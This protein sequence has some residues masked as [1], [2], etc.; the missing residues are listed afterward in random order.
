MMGYAVETAD[1]ERGHELD[2]LAT[3]DLARYHPTDGVYEVI[4][5]ASRFVKP[6]G[7]RIELDS[8]EQRLAAMGWQAVATGDDHRLVIAVVDTDPTT[9]RTAVANITTLPVSRIEVVSCD[10]LPRTASGKI[11]YRAVLAM[12]PGHSERTTAAAKSVTALFAEVLCRRDIRPTDTFASLGGDS[13]S[14]VECSLELERLLGRAPADW[15]VR[16]VEE[17]EQVRPARRTPLLDTSVLL[18][19]LAICAIVASHMK[20]SRLQGGGHLLLAL[21]GYNFAKFQLSITGTRDRVVAGVR[22]AA[23]VALPA[24]TWIGINMLVAGGYSLGCALLINN[25]SGSDWR[26]EGRWNYWIIEVFIQLTVFCSLLLA[27]PALR[28]VERQFPFGFALALLLPLL[29]F[30]FELIVIGSNYNYLFRTHT[31]AWIFLVG[32]AIQRA[33]RTW[34]RVTISAVSVVLLLGFFDQP[35]REWFIVAGLMALTWIPAIPVP[36]VVHRLLGVLAAASLW[37]FLVHWQVWPPLERVVGRE[38]SFAL[39]LATGIVV[40]RLVRLG[41]RLLPAVRAGARTSGRDRAT[42]ERNVPVAA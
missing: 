28:R 22:S 39:T 5:R 42:W 30:R 1:L 35:Q 37:I 4:G 21:I 38:L 18:R 25:Y 19:A 7:L 16:T 17:L 12:V 29:V 24:S 32:W 8:L 2:E 33:R 6:F 41:Q 34:Q 10:S 31:V 9:V 26:R 23:R 36:R 3:G 14:Y 15:H 20:L 11:D 13:L 27:V 40:W